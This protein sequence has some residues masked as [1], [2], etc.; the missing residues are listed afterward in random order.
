MSHKSILSVSYKKF[1]NHFITK[2]DKGVDYQGALHNS[3]S[4]GNHPFEV[5]PS[6]LFQNF[7]FALLNRSN[8]CFPIFTSALYSR[9][10]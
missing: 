1:E 4:Q 7:I 2:N 8:S 5:H 10:R 3:P 6:N 9:F